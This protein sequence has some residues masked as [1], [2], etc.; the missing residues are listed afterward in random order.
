LLVNNLQSSTTSPKTIEFTKEQE[1]ITHLQKELLFGKFGYLKNSFCI[2]NLFFDLSITFKHIIWPMSNQ[3]APIYFSG[4]NSLM[5][6][7]WYH[8]GVK[9]TDLGHFGK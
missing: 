5:K 3:F 4:K 7:L 9:K 6:H 2:P 1:K 8:W